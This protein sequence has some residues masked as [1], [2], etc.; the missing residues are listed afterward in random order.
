MLE[1]FLPMLAVILFSLTLIALGI[2]AVVI[3]KRLPKHEN[4]AFQKS[5][6]SSEHD[7][8][9]EPVEV[10]HPIPLHPPSPLLRLRFQDSLDIQKYATACKDS[11]VSY[12]NEQLKLGMGDGIVM[13]ITA[14]RLRPSG[15][16]MIFRASKNGQTLLDKGF[17]VLAHDKVSGRILPV[18][19]DVKTGKIIEQLK[20]APIATTLS[21]LG[22]LSAAVVGAA[23]IVAGADIAKRL[24][25]AEKKLGLLLAFRRIDQLATVER[26]YTSAKELAGGPMTQ[27][28][29]LEIWRLRGELR[30]LRIV[31]RREWEH[32]L[33]QIEG[34]K[35][36]N[37][38]KKKFHQMSFVGRATT[39]IVN[40]KSQE[41][42]AKQFP[43]TIS[44]G[45]AEVAFI[46]YSLRLEQLLA[47]A[48]GTEKE[49]M[50][51][52]ADELKQLEV[53]SQLL[54][55]KN[56]PILLKE[57]AKPALEAIKEIVIQYRSLLPENSSLN[58][59]PL[60]EPQQTEVFE[61]GE[62]EFQKLMK[63][64]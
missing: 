8:K 42:R 28:K 13:T 56:T 39:P 22:A 18:L 37:W 32:H 20:G 1:P 2:M 16:E 11:A 38:F 35:E 52:L 61:K 41:T 40:T 21:R 59:I 17:A 30:E 26:I 45:Q 53:L 25:S 57:D 27:F 49:F 14:L 12:M 4:A 6:V 44:E 55:S 43:A 48:S 50:D 62:G 3:F 54:D 60:I 63:K 46:E 47:V 24:K 23:H 64:I 9:A 31:W 29:R 36:D 5:L 34:P 19:K 15:L 51:T 7:L 58:L 10:I 33:N